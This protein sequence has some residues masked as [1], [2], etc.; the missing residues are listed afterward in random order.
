M[1]FQS[2]NFVTIAIP[3]LNEEEHICCCLASLLSQVSEEPPNFVRACLQALQRPGVTSVVV[4]MRTVGYRRRQRA[5]AAAQ[6][7]R[8]GNGGAAHRLA[9][10]SGFV[11]HGHHA[12]FDRAFFV[13]VGGYDECF[14]HNEDAE[15]D[16]RAVR[17]GGRLWMCAEATIIYFP[18]RRFVALAKQYYRHGQGRARTLLTH[19]YRP[20]LRQMAPLFI[21]FGMMAG[22]LLLP[23]SWVFGLVPLTYVLLCH[24]RGLVRAIGARDPWLAG[25]GPAY[26]TMHLSWA[27]GFLGEVLARVQSKPVRSGPTTDADGVRANSISA[28]LPI[29]R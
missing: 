2:Q 27:V 26:M 29:C 15:F 5:F 25:M 22:A 9:R 6:N 17:A 16:Y 19:G 20:K 14:S 24:F 11:D 3:T 1:P 10:K 8:L 28:R 23:V 13:R 4:P 12:A 18:R 7:S 21:L